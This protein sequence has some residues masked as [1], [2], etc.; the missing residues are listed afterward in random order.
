MDGVSATRPSGRQKAT[1]GHLLCLCMA[2]IVLQLLAWAAE[3]ARKSPAP[4]GPSDLQLLTDGWA[5]A[6]DEVAVLERRLTKNP[7]DLSSRML[8]VSYYF[9]HAQREQ[10]LRHIY[11][12]IEN[13]PGSQSFDF[14]GTGVHALESPLGGPEAFQKVRELWLAQTQKYPGEPRVHANAARL[15]EHDDPERAA[16]FWRRARTLEPDNQQWTFLLASS[17]GLL[18]DPMAASTEQRRRHPS[19]RPLP[20]GS[21]TS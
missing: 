12:I 5:L 15:I 19:G 16:E 2:A 14:R 4:A 21:W 9:Q 6:P 7:G 17:T 20:T 18:S 8:L 1:L 13:D 11:W 10:R 3:P